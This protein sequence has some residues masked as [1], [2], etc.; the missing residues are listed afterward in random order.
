MLS[1]HS[2]KYFVI[3]KGS[4]GLFTFFVAFLIF[5]CTGAGDTT[6]LAAGFFGL[7]GISSNWKLIECFPTDYYN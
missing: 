4:G 1:A 3:L 7:G 5:F 6:F 2:V